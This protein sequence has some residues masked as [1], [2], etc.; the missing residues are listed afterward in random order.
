MTM[1]A[2]ARDE[3]GHFQG[4]SVIVMQG[5]S[6]AETAEVMACREELALV[7]DLMLRKVRIATD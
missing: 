4:E 3:A 5:I 1:A 7:S 6:D 2:V